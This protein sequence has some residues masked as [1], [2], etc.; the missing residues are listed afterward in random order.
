MAALDHKGPEG[1]GP[2]SG[3]KLGLCK[4]EPDEHIEFN[5]GRGMGKYRHLKECM[6]RQGNRNK[7]SEII[8]K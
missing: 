1:K 2:K 4:K 6:E 7:A 3:R 5:Y 8:R